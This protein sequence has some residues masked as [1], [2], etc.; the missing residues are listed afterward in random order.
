MNV[1]KLRREQIIELEI[2]AENLKK[3]VNLITYHF[4]KQI[5]REN[6]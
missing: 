5:K 2:K 1:I 6:I 4:L 3:N